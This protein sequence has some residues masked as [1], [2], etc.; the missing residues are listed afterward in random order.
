MASEHIG[1]PGAA[2]GRTARLGATII[3]RVSHSE[4]A[5]ILRMAAENDR[6]LSREVRRAI[7]FYL[8]HSQQSGEPVRKGGGP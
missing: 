7:R 5:D 3:A 6:T 8:T 2:H 4:R 1:Q